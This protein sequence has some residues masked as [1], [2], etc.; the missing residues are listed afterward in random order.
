MHIKAVRGL[1]QASSKIVKLTFE[2]LSGAFSI[3]VY[4]QEEHTYTT[5]NVGAQYGAYTSGLPFP[6]P[7]G[8]GFILCKKPKGEASPGPSCTYYINFLS[9]GNK[10]NP[11]HCYWGRVHCSFESSYSFNCRSNPRSGHNETG[12]LPFQA[13][14]PKKYSA[15]G[16]CQRVNAKMG[17]KGKLVYKGTS[18]GLREEC[19]GKYNSQTWTYDPI[20]VY[21]YCLV[22]FQYFQF[23]FPAT[24]KLKWFHIL[25]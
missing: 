11:T 8:P 4:L 7:L 14:D 6:P 13:S 12:C 2:Q 19:H 20:N 21:L 25:W 10:M 15:L 17:W 5:F 18:T 23:G 3:K 24:W 9:R 1:F 22:K 16:S